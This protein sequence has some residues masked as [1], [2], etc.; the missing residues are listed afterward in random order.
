MVAKWGEIAVKE[1]ASAINGRLISGS[2]DEFI[3]GLSTDSRRMVPGHIFLAIKG[4]RYDGHNFLTE[5]IN[6]GAAGVIVESDTTIPDELLTKNLIVIN[7]SSTLNALG[8]LALW[9][10][11]QWGGKV[12][13]ITGSNGK[14][15]TKEMAAS[16]L[17]LK[18]NTMK[19]PGN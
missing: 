3:K 2:P 6:A 11:K 4:E 14:S 9:W 18:A 15:T 1:V 8:D 10:R 17:S 12:I 7:V 19:S 13:A 16:I 5:A